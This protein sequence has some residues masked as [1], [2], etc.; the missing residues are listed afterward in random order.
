[1]DTLLNKIDISINR[2]S[3]SSIG[4]HFTTNDVLPDLN[5]SLDLIS[6]GGKKI[7]S[8]SLDTR[9]YYGTKL[10]KDVLTGEIYN[11]IGVIVKAL[12]PICVRQINSIEAM[13]EA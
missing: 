12:S 13:I 11:A 8:V 1:M 6:V 3:I 4:L 7:T 10:D 5:V 9:N 2:A